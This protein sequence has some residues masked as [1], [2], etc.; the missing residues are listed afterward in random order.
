MYIALWKHDN[1]VAYTFP[2]KVLNQ[3][4]YDIQQVYQLK[5]GLAIS[6]INHA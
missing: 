6:S 2:E 1:S 5:T 4:N 3:N